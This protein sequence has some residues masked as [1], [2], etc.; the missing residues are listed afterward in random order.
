M[1]EDDGAL[2]IVFDF[3]GVLFNWQPDELV[4]HYLPRHATGAAAIRAL[5]AGV[6]QGFGG[7]WAQ[8]DRGVLDEHELTRRIVARTGLP[9]REVAALVNGVPP[10]LTPRSDTVDL[11]LRLRAAGAALHFLSNMPLP[12][13]AY[14]NRTHPDLLGQFRNG[15]YSSHV[16][17]I[18]PEAE[19]YELASQSFAA[20]SARLVLLD[21]IAANVDAARASGWK[22]LQ[23]TDARSCEQA[24][25]AN[26]WWPKA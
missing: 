11:L 1:S 2:R 5:V 24:L 18:K 8:F 4:R 16:R 7:D 6:F 19:L 26:A 23:F 14:L 21:D 25:R 20:P 17:L 13:A 22:A 10:S 9:A 3:G 12:Y 15:L